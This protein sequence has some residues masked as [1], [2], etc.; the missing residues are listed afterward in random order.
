MQ[1]GEERGI[2]LSNHARE[3]EDIDNIH[4]HSYK[5]RSLQEQQYHP[6][7]PVGGLLVGSMEQA[8]VDSFESSPLL[9]NNNDH[10]HNTFQTSWHYTNSPRKESILSRWLRIIKTS[11]SLHR[12]FCFG[13]IDGLLTGAGLTG[14]SSGL[15]LLDDNPL[16]TKLATTIICLCLAACSADALCMSIGHVLSTY[17]LSD[18]AIEERK[19]EELA[20]RTNTSES[21]ARLVDLFLL[22][23]MLK[24][25]AMSLAD[26]LEGYPDIFLNLLTSSCLSTSKSTF[27]NLLSEDDSTRS[28]SPL[29]DHMEM[30]DTEQLCCPGCTDIDPN[31]VK[32]SWN[33]ALM[34]MI[35]FS[36]FSIFPALVYSLFDKESLHVNHNMNKEQGTNPLTATI[37]FNSFIMFLLGVW[38]SKFFSSNWILFG[39]ETVLVLL[40]CIMASY[41]LGVFLKITFLYPK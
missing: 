1:Q 22:N 4:Y 24:I 26:T 37:A 39:V 19:R 30:E 40:L 36:F 2:C 5:D 38:K 13:A 12:S 21:K 18:H 34:M 29:N 15:G 25:D 28:P 33:E 17:I 6:S 14:A 10:D 11:E 8:D 9:N 16:Q 23:G 3:G 31:L 35:S 32:D 27:N 41:G 7:S 20:L